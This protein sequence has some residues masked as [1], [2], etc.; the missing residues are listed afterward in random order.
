MR[1]P[2]NLVLSRQPSWYKMIRLIFC[3]NFFDF[4]FCQI[5]IANVECHGHL[6]PIGDT[7]CND[8]LEPP[9]NFK[10]VGVINKPLNSKPSSTTTQSNTSKRSTTSMEPTT[11]EPISE[12]T[13]PKGILSSEWL[14][15]IYYIP[16]STVRYDFIKLI[17]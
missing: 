1:S 17:F 13:L 5:A 16:R 3:F 10:F 7:S 9:S 4:N 6:M 8:F 14:Y 2:F 15:W 12:V 11:L